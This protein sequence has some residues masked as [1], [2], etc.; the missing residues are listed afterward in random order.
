[1]KIFKHLVSILIVS[2]M[3]YMPHIS[4]ANEDNQ[5]LGTWI[6]HIIWHDSNL[7][8]ESANVDTMIT[9]TETESISVILSLNPDDRK[10][11]RKNV[12]YIIDD[13]YNR[14]EVCTV[15]SSSPCE[16]VYFQDDDKAHFYINPLDFFEMVRVD[17]DMP[18]I[19]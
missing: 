17:D 7:I 2:V 11:D 14:V 6:G 18:I 15:G 9:F 10:T 5:L 13:L 19:D 3:I 8:P 1:M 12:T 4:Y 16:I